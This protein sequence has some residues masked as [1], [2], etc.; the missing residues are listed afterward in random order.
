MRLM[1]FTLLEGLAVR[2]APIA[3]RSGRAGSYGRIASKPAQHPQTPQIAATLL[4]WYLKKLR[5]L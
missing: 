4:F 3:L 5:I 2:F 1:T